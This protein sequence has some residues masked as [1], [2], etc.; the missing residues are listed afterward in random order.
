MWNTERPEDWCPINHSCDASCWFDESGAALT[1]VA[2]RALRPGDQITLDYG[3]FS[4][5]LVEMEEF[6]CQCGSAQYCRGVIR[7]SDHL[8]PQVMEMYG[9]HV[10]DYVRMQ[11]EKVLG[12]ASTTYGHYS[13]SSVH[14]RN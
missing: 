10:T 8:L 11:R 1:V 9:D 6:A 13:P 12:S 3:T 5:A 14:S 7:A 4:C 2:R